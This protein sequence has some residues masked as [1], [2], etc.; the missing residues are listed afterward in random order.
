[1]N[2]YQIPN[3]AIVKATARTALKGRWVE[4]ITVSSLGLFSILIINLLSSI[5]ASSNEHSLI[6]ASYIF[7]LVVAVFVLVPLF[8]GIV[9][10]FWRLTD[11][12]NDDISSAFY[13]FGS[14]KRYVRAVKLA[15]ILGWRVVTAIILC[16]LPYFVANV[17]SSTWLYQTLG[18]DI[19]LWAANLI[20]IES[21]LYIVGVIC[22]VLYISRYYLVAVIAAMDEDLLL[23]EAVHI[24]CM[25]SKRSASAFLFLAVSLLGWVLLTFLLAP[26]IYTLPLILACYAVHSRFAM[27]NYNLVLDY[28]E[29][30]MSGSYR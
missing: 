20:L 6:Y 21:F 14:R 9:R 1:M 24:S 27:T 13:Y 8:L 23:L 30:N 22:A 7:A 15:F 29:N 19:P 26:A 10:F 28:Y 18:Q 4:A 5:V 3:S 2:P 16:M 11:S 12:A 17:L 25:V